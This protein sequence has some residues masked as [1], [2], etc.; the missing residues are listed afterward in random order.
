MLKRAIIVLALAVTLALPF[1]L[2]PHRASPAEADD[3][4]VIITPHNEAIR[5]EFTLGFADWYRAKTGR[6]VFLDWR[7]IGGTS[8]IARYLEGEYVASFRNYWTGRL[9]KPWSA[10]IQSGFQNGRLGGD[11]P[12]LVREARAAFLASQAGCG[13]D[14]FFGGG[15]FDYERQARTGRLVDSG[16]ARLHPE[17][18]TE[19]ALPQTLGGE[20]NW[21]RDGLWYGTVLSSYG[22]LFNRDSLRRLGVDHEPRQ[23]ADL[24]DP[25]YVGQ[26]GMCDPTKSGAIAAAIENVVQ[27]QMHRRVEALA[28]GGAGEAATQG[29]IRQG[30]VDGLRLLQ[31]VGANARYFTDAS[32]KPPIDVATGDCAAGM[33]I[34]FYGREQEEAVRRRTGGLDRLGYASPAGGSAY[35]VD[36]IALLRGAP[37]PSVALAFIEY[38]LSID[39]QKLWNF[40]TGT[41]G[42]PRQFALRRL[43][44]RRD[45]YESGEWRRYMSDPDEN[46]YAQRDVLVHHHAWTGSLFQELAFV[47]RV[48]TEDTHPELVRA[49]RAIIAAPAPARERALAVLQDMSAVDYDQC[50]GPIKKAL[51]SKNLVDAVRLS[52]DLDDRFR[53]NYER[54][55]RI[56]AGGD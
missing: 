50:L 53:R 42:G 7:M 19:Q 4:L 31:L 20:I 27:E 1:V 2:R 34:D 45:F 46:P 40:R 15:P 22:I 39:G 11:A 47:V 44:V 18:F 54:A 25:R 26:L 51:A 49:W 5:H 41:P 55:E 12:A 24:T 8:E 29:A 35:S 21:D 56:A 28:K 10:E 23:W 36:P 17:W 14:L 52:R 37:H 30:W 6:T 13:I 32:Q 9:G 38:T 16:I 48:T 3:T 33:C 43:P